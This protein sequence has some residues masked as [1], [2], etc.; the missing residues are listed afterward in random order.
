M[1]K[2][3]SQDWVEIWYMVKL[4][5]LKNFSSSFEAF[6]SFSS[7]LQASH[8]NPSSHLPFFQLKLENRERRR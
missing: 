3:K 8:A 5:L 2:I 7:I 4:L 1:L 6:L